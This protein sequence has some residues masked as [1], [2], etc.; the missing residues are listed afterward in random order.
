MVKS[1][2]LRRQNTRVQKQAPP[3]WG[4]ACYSFLSYKLKIMV[5]SR[6]VGKGSAWHRVYAWY[7]LAAVP[8]GFLM[9]PAVGATRPYGQGLCAQLEGRKHQVNPTESPLL[10]TGPWST[11]FTA[12]VRVF[13]KATRSLPNKIPLPRPGSF[14]EP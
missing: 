5:V 12:H 10:Q 4:W 3:L 13:F 11:S 14:P 6:G 2:A 1:I 8:I 7:T 9:Q